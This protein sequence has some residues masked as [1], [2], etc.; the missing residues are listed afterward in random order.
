MNTQLKLKFYYEHVL[1]IHYHETN[2]ALYHAMTDD[3]VQKFVDP[4]NLPKD[5]V[6]YDLDPG[7]GNFLKYMKDQGYTAV[8]GITLDRED[9][10]NLLKQG[11][12][13]SFADTNFL[14]NPDESVD[15][16]FARHTLS[17]SPFPYISL[18]EYNRVLKP[19]GY[20]YIDVPTPNSA[21]KHESN[22]NQ[23]SIMDREMWLNLLQRTG[24]DVQWYDYR[25]PMKYLD[26]SGEFEEHCY[27][28]I[29]R[30][31]RPVDIK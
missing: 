4:L 17:Q 9:A 10:N 15:M 28:F 14:A 16:I 7:P 5:A 3:I 26:G 27:V 2:H 24:F 25:V 11:Y 8:T 21:L 29:C 13:I 1:G 18:L 19:N 22:R 6:I 12:S 31:R 23:F 30:R 20:L